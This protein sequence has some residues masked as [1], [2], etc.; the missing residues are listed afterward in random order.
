MRLPTFDKPRVISC[1]QLLP[2]YV[3]IPRGCLDSLLQL[4]DDVG[5]RPQIRDERQHG[6]LLETQFLGNLTELQNEAV[7]ALLN[8]DT[9]VLAATTAFGKTVVGAKMIAAR[10]RN[11]LVLV[12]RKYL[13]DQ[14]NA[15][16]QAF[17]DIAPEE[18]GVYHGT[19]K[20][21]T[22]VIDI[23]VMQSLV[24]RGVVSDLVTDYGHLIV[25][26]LCQPLVRHFTLTN[27]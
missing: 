6:Q 7:A 20:K 1:A 12:H 9:G 10:A 13:A 24:P 8:Y 22:G 16:L 25:D 2:K 27:Q 23:A 5:I 4:L 19:K 26:P 21:L 18:I 3:A 15:Q 11:T 17:L 14:W